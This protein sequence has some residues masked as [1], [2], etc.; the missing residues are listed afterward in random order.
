M[1]LLFM[2]ALQLLCSCGK[3]LQTALDPWLAHGL[4][5][6]AAFYQ[7]YQPLVTP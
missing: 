5:A 7:P 1:F 3:G 4:T 2:Q 6:D